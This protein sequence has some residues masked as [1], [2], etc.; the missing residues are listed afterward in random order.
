MPQSI[1]E[2]ITQLRTLLAGRRRGEDQALGTLVARTLELA[3]LV[4]QQA[5]EIE[6]L[7]QRLDLR[8]R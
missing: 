8:S 1:S 5:K 6:E 4:Q 7:K 2:L 3:E